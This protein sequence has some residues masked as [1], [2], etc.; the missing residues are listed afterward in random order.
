[1]FHAS[2]LEPEVTQWM[3]NASTKFKKKKIFL[4]SIIMRVTAE[5]H[6]SGF[7]RKWKRNSFKTFNIF[8]GIIVN[9]MLLPFVQQ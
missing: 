8:L 7:T 3:S 1:M 4:L 2:D 6:L 9:T 5:T